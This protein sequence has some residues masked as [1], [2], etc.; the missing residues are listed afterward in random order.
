MKIPPAVQ[1]AIDRI[2]KM[3]SVVRLLEI[4]AAYNEAGGGLLAAG[5]AYGALFAALT[6]LLFAV[7]LI[8]FVIGDAVT[9]EQIV[10]RI[11]NQLPPIEPIVRDGLLTVASHAGALSILGMAGLGWSASQFY[12]SI[13]AAFARIFKR[14]PERSPIARIVRGLISVVII[15]G[16]LAAGIATSAL[17][18]LLAVDLPPGPA[19]DAS[20]IVSAVAYPVLTVLVVI[21]A[22]GVV[23]RLVPNAH[24]PL[25]SLGPP[26]I[27]AGLVIAALTELFVFVAPRLVGSLE[28][29]GGFVA[30]FAALTWL[31][32]AFQVLLIGAAWTRQRLPD[33]S[34]LPGPKVEDLMPAPAVSP[35]MGAPRS[36]ETAR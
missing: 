15:V 29:F 24:V 19:G 28:V 30:V 8:G 33:D 32:W 25:R 5:L 2:Q 34:P 11:T 21:V 35:D 13:D 1:R 7:G 22:V 14:E 16:G 23:Y 9:R 26:A 4:L 31:S 17:Q 36:P 6:G 27:A 18:A 12:G 10:T 3:P 20:R